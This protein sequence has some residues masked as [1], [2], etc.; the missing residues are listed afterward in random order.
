MKVKKDDKE[1]EWK[2]RSREYLS[3]YR[4][5]IVGEQGK[6]EDDLLKESK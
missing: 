3:L 2:G 6:K 4:D 1:H 5:G